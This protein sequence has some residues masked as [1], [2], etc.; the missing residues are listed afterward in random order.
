MS[1]YKN[2]FQL[3]A[4]LAKAECGENCHS[5]SA[6][7][8]EIECNNVL[9]AIDKISQGEIKYLPQAVNIQ[10]SNEHG[11]F[12]EMDDLVKYMVGTHCR[13][14]KEALD[15]IAKGNGTDK[16]LAICIEAKELKKAAKKAKKKKMEI[17][18][19]CKKPS[20]LCTC[21]K[22]KSES[23][24]TTDDEDFDDGDLDDDDEELYECAM[25]VIE[26]CKSE[27]INLLQK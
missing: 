22:S 8:C 15:E 9:D 23:Y 10:V 13:S 5:Y 1:L 14:F 16:P 18:P 12:V 3:I 6:N 21:N 4:E 26:K 7:T 17:C 25:S 19:D 24:N 27:G 20:Y 2:T 11:Y